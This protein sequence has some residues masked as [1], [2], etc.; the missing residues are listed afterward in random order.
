MSFLLMVLLIVDRKCQISDSLNYML[1]YE[2]GPAFVDVPVCK[3]IAL[4]LRGPKPTV[5]LSMYAP[6]AGYGKVYRGVRHT[7]TFCNNSVSLRM[8]SPRSQ[9]CE[10][11]S[12]ASGSFCVSFRIVDGFMFRDRDCFSVSGSRLG[13]GKSALVI[14]EQ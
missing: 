3:E 11:G 8:S 14:V 10:L 13:R 2:G 5:C 1:C 6:P 4:P 7:I 9:F 12:S